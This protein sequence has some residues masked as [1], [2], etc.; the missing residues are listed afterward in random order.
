MLVLSYLLFWVCVLEIEWQNRRRLHYSSSGG[1]WEQ[2][3][4]ELLHGALVSVLALLGG[5]TALFCDG[6]IGEF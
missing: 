2:K 6:W 5:A 3:L 4:F 1:L